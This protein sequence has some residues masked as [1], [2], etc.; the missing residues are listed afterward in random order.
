MLTLEH[1][2]VVRLRSKGD[3]QALMTECNF[4]KL[5]DRQR[6]C[7]RLV[8]DGF[9]TKEIAGRIQASPDAIDKTIKGAMAT[10]ALY[11]FSASAVPGTS[12]TPP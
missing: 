4:D 10:H 6:A 7:L 3:T 2:C 8:R 5:T 12:T 11:R 1:R 9:T